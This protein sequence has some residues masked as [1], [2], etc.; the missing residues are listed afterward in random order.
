MPVG[1]VAQVSLLPSV[2]TLGCDAADPHPHPCPCP[3]V[4]GTSLHD[5]APW[6]PG[7]SVGLSLLTPTVIYVRD[8]MK[9]VSQCDGM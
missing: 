6:A 7:T 8:C 4:S 5:A 2:K 9:M 3:Q 1:A